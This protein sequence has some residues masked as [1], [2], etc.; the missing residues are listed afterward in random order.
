MRKIKFCKK[1]WLKH[2]IKKYNDFLLR[3]GIREAHKRGKNLQFGLEGKAV[4]SEN[5]FDNIY[6]PETENGIDVSKILSIGAEIYPE[7]GRK[8]LVYSKMLNRLEIN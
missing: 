3:E 2:Q 5:V 8:Y 1:I 4:V 7:E 6:L